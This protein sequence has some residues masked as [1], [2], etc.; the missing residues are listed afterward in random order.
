MSLKANGA[1]GAFLKANVRVC[2]RSINIY[3]IQLTSCFL[4]VESAQGFANK[5]AALDLNFL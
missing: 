2:A 5:A 4:H 1:S 3:M